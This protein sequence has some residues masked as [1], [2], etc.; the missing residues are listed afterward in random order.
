VKKRKR[1][2]PQQ[3]TRKSERTKRIPDRYKDYHMHSIINS[4]PYD[5]RL[6]ALESMIASGVLKNIEIDTA[7]KI[8]DAIMK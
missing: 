6:Q 4:R 5:H 8:F 7:R 2:L 1:Q 3:P